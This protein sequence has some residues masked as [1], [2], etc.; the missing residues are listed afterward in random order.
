MHR[1]RFS[2][3]FRPLHW[4]LNAI[5]WM[6]SLTRG[7]REW[8]RMEQELLIVL[9]TDSNEISLQDFF[10][11]DAVD[12]DRHTRLPAESLSPMLQAA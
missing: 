2:A 3:V 10:D 12:G 8:A 7:D 1:P 6:Q 9:N 4:W 11:L 5:E